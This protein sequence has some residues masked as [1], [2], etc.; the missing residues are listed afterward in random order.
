MKY[1]PSAL[2]NKNLYRHLRFKYP[3]LIFDD[4]NFELDIDGNPFWIVPTIKYTGIGLKEEITGSYKFYY[5][6]RNNGS[7]KPTD[8]DLMGSTDGT[9]WFLIRNFTKDAD[10]LPV[11]ST[12]TFT[13]EI[14]DAPQPFSQIRMV[15]NATNTSSI[16]W[17]MS[18]FKFYSVSVMDPDAADEQKALFT[19]LVSNL[20]YRG[21]CS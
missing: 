12:G 13:S 8:F 21:G 2:F 16:F 4:A 19:T 1:L 5:A 6:P 18:E 3:T 11:T 17:T 9:Y 10:G 20:G 15:V 7:N 14:Y